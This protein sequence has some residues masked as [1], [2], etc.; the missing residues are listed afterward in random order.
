MK[1]RVLL[2]TG[3]SGM[4]AETARL[5][6]REGARVFVVGLEPDH[7]RALAEEIGQAGW[8]AC[9]LTAPGAARA[10]VR[11]CLDRF[12][13]ID[14]L[15]NV[16]GISGR[17][18]GDVPVHE[19]TDEAFDRTLAFNVKT[20]FLMSKE[21]VGWMVRH[22]AEGAI[23]NMASVIAFSPEPRHFATHAYATSKAAVIGLTKAMA[24]YYAPHK[25]RV[26]AVAPG[27]VETP[28]SARAQQSPEIQE[29]IKGK[30]PLAG[31]M[32]GAADVARAALFLL[33]D[34]ARMITGEVLTVDAGW[35]VSG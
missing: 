33:G 10:A 17:K 30:Q 22:R 20:M 27:L 16:A 18:Y 11:A 24:A 12:G 5:A 6:A 29:F 1:D 9:D 8:H 4:G 23:L 32:I 19:C 28:M 13:R 15:F 14:A 25:I 26:N 21:V 34:A 2:V 31:G 3:S 35:R 7:C